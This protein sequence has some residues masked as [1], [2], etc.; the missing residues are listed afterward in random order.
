MKKR[1]L[2]IQVLLE[3]VWLTLLIFATRFVTRELMFIVPIGGIILFHYFMPAF[4][5]LFLL[6]GGYLPG[7]SKSNGHSFSLLPASFYLLSFLY[8]FAITLFSLLPSIIDNSLL[9]P[10]SW[11]I[12]IAVFLFLLRSGYLPGMGKKMSMGKEKKYEIHCVKAESVPTHSQHTAVVGGGKTYKLVHTE[13][14][15]FPLNIGDDLVLLCRHDRKSGMYLADA[16]LNNTN[17]VRMV[18]GWELMLLILS[19]IMFI[20]TLVGFLVGLLSGAGWLF[21]A[22]V[23]LFLPILVGIRIRARFTRLVPF[24]FSL[25]GVTDKE[26]M[27]RKLANF[28]GTTLISG[29]E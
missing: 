26:S 18:A 23:G 10:L 24:A 20:S 25:E 16:A 8:I 9:N 6:Q 14:G 17:N 12:P 13:Q 22:V 15:N 21:G 1:N 11:F 7:T 4:V 28:K 19:P 2:L 5:S 3:S 29:Y 27:T